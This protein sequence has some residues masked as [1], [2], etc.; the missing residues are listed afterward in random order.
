MAG[1]RLSE[2]SAAQL[3]LLHVGSLSMAT[4]TT[5]ESNALPFCVEFFVLF[6]VV[7]VVVLFCQI[8]S[9]IFVF[10]SSSEEE[11]EHICTHNEHNNKNAA[12]ID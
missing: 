4:T 2:R 10:A 3:D 11:E 9:N 5:I 1:W 7:V 12:L 8:K 6:V